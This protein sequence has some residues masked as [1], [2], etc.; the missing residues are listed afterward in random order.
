MKNNKFFVFMT[1]GVIFFLNGCLRST[2]H[3]YI[4][5][6]GSGKV[7]FEVEYHLDET[8][9]FDESFCD[10]V[11]SVIHNLKNSTTGVELWKD[12]SFKQKSEEVMV[13]R[14]IA[15]FS[16]INQ[17]FFNENGLS[18]AMYRYH[19]TPPDENGQLG[20]LKLVDFRQP[21]DEPAPSATKMNVEW[22]EQMQLVKDRFE[23]A[24]SM[25]EATI[26]QTKMSVIFSL[27][28]NVHE[29]V[30][31]KKY[32]ENSIRLDFD[33]MQ[34]LENFKQLSQDEDWL[35]KNL[36]R[37]ID[38]FDIGPM[39]D[40]KLNK[41]LF[42]TPGPV[43]ARFK[44]QDSLLFDSQKE[45]TEGS[46]DFPSFDMSKLKMEENHNVPLSPLFIVQ[47]RM[48]YQ[49]ENLP[50]P[51]TLGRSSVYSISIKAPLPSSVFALDGGDIEE[52]VTDSGQSL[53]LSNDII[54]MFDNASI[55]PSHNFLNFD[56]FLASPSAASRIIKKLSGAVYCYSGGDITTIDLGFPGFEPG[57]VSLDK[58]ARIDSL[59]RDP[60]DYSKDILTLLFRL[61]PQAILDITFLDED[62]QKID[63]E[64]NLKTQ[65]DGSVVECRHSGR[66]PLRGR[67]LLKTYTDI[68][69][70]KMPFRIENVDL[71][72]RPVGQ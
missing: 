17:V 65:I 16:D 22:E 18:L 48:L 28:G 59:K 68:K 30:N 57:F 69:R 29:F 7:E 67:I 70:I 11:G 38:I 50:Q 21:F 61:P 24:L 20:E 23:K 41:A 40:V 60:A 14:G 47:Q 39:G 56:V 32:S 4:N 10:D 54:K 6:D 27:S 63:V 64:R 1:V 31:F 72:G 19:Y 42:G 12:L 43:V 25:M 5:T 55:D 45:I 36:E 34:F 46:L 49:H 37:G 35:K 52:A 53:L 44:G 13:L 15:F 71:L 33:G 58:T 8:F 26:G 62:D 66:Y 9:C 51:Q 3:Y 2:Q